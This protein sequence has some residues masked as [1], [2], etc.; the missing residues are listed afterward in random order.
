MRSKFE[1]LGHPIHPMLVALPIG[2]FAWSFIALVI[3]IFSDD[4]QTW[5]DISLYTG[6]AAVISALVA[7]LPGL[8]DLLTMAWSTNARLVALIHMAANISAVA[9]FA[10]ALLLMLDDNATSG[11]ELTAATALQAIGLG[12]LTLGGY[13]GGHLVYRFHLAMVP[14]DAEQE[15]AERAHHVVRTNS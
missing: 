2:L 14:D 5:Y 6:I 7:A 1:F 11:T 8:G 13:L 3:Y 10:I 15:R 12:A 9:L 4:N